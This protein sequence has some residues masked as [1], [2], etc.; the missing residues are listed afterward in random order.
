MS[1][2]KRFAFAVMVSMAA[3]ACNA[4]ND[5]ASRDATPGGTPGATG[6]S[7]V[8]MGDRNY[9]EDMAEAG[10]AEVTLGEMAQQKAASAEVKQ[11]ASMIVRDHQRANEELKSIAA[12]HNIELKAELDNEHKDLRERLTKLSGA[13]FDREY[14]KAMVDGHEE[15]VDDAKDK[16]EHSDNAEIKQWSSKALPTLQQHLERARQ[17][18]EA[19]EKQ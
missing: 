12:K 18:N 17:I 9:V 2:T 8:A 4:N 13:E 16:A 11:F 5:R 7:G 19:L 1:A 14:M 6:T 3:L 15:A 10:Q